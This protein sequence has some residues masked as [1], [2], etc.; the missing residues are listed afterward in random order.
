M[1]VFADLPELAHILP[2]NSLNAFLSSEGAESHEK[3]LK[4]VFHSLMTCDKEKITSSLKKLLSRLEK[5]GKSHCIHLSVNTMI[6]YQ[7]HNQ[8]YNLQFDTRYRYI[9][10]KIFYHVLQY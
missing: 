3:E 4:S 5:E 7:Q 10:W 1:Y 2:E 9:S 8:Q 6:Y